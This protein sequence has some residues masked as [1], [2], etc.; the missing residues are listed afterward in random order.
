M[1]KLINEPANVVTEALGGMAAAHADLIR[2]DFDNNVVIRADAPRPGKVGVISGGA[3]A[4]M[5]GPARTFPVAARARCALHPHPDQ[6]SS[7]SSWQV[8]TCTQLLPGSH[9]RS[10]SHAASTQTPP[11]CPR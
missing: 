3:G 9:S 2:V 10:V 6:C 7:R 11:T 5:A 1:K 4:G 8:S